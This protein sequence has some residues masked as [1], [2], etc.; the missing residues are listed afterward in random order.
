M[1]TKERFIDTLYEMLDELNWGLIEWDTDD[2]FKK[3][4]E[5]AWDRT[6]RTD[7]IHYRLH[8]D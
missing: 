6:E 7:P 1:V 8:E 5:D 2:D 4:L 3:L